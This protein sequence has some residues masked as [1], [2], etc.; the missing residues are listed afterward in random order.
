MPAARRLCVTGVTCVAALSLSMCGGGGGGTLTQ[1]TQ[2]INPPPPVQPTSSVLRGTIVD[3]SS[4]GG[5]AG[6]TLTFTQAGVPANPTVSSG[7]GGA[8]EYTLP[9]PS[10]S[11]QQVEV[12]APG[13]VT[14]RTFVRATI[15]TRA[16]V[17]IDIIREATPF[18]LTYYRELVRDLFDEPSLPPQPLRRWTSAPNFYIAKHNP[19]TGQDILPSEIDLLIA[20]IRASVPQMTGGLFEA[21]QIEVG[22]GE[23]PPQTGVINV[24]FVHE[25]DATFCGKAFVGGNPGLITINYGKPGCQSTCGAFAPRTVA[26]EVGHALGFYH[27][28]QGSV[29]NTAWFNSDCGVTTF[30]EAE[31]YHA[32]VAYARVPGNRDPDNDPASAPLLRNGDGPPVEIV[33]R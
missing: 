3:T 12:S 10:E 6:A 31:R 19:R 11:A 17:V 33:C 14:R 29:L 21:G 5:V 20:A 32:K 27:V 7:A 30:S 16:D 22:S 4:G 2:P 25:P 8:W 28:A 1:P 26:H 24:K 13:Y 18:S 9:L 15:G 23:R